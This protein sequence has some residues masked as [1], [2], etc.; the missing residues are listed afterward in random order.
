[1]MDVK[2]PFRLIYLGTFAIILTGLVYWLAPAQF[3]V[4]LHK[5]SLVGL[6]GVFGYWLDRHLF[7]YAR[8]HTLQ[9]DRE[10]FQAAT[11]RRAIVVGASLVAVALAL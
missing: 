6:A 5:F 11:L 10:A 1:M 3:T 2:E 9:G 8:P 4:I 7:P